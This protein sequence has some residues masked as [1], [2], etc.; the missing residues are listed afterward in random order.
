MSS[1][2]STIYNS[3]NL[4]YIANFF[5]SG[6]GKNDL[7]AHF[8]MA[9]K[10]YLVRFKKQL[11]PPRLKSGNIPA[12]NRTIV[13]DAF[14]YLPTDELARATGKCNACGAPRNGRYD[15]DECTRLMHSI[16]R[17]SITPG[18][19]CETRISN[20]PTILPEYKPQTTRKRKRKVAQ[21]DFPQM[22]DVGQE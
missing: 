14:A 2:I 8:G 4:H 19:T 6:D 12:L 13:F 16:A 1:F 7:D 3:F 10:L 21:E 15:H 5:E 20:W 22:L 17:S 9:Y 11:L 18:V